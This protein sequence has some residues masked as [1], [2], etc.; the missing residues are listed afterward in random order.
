MKAMKATKAMKAM[1]ARK[2]M[3]KKVVSKI[4][5]RRAG[6]VLGLFGEE[7]DDSRWAAQERP[8]E[9]QARE[10][11]VP[12]VVRA[13]QAGV[14]RRKAQS[15]GRR[16]QEGQGV[17][18]LRLEPLGEACAAQGIGERWP[19]GRPPRAWPHST[20]ANRVDASRGSP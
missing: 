10:G 18:G 16:V 6:E 17:D 8:D 12:Q 4:A 1:K 9:E 20:R 3:K 5:R 2:A 11:R 14:G 7:G 19:A 15:L 13:R